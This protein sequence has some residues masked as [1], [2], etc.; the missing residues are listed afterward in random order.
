MNTTKDFRPKRFRIFD[1]VKIRWLLE[2]DNF[3]VVFGEDIFVCV[4]SWKVVHNFAVRIYLSFLELLTSVSR[5]SSGTDVG[6]N[7]T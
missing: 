5:T 7:R 6:A 3:C 4:R 2:A 1:S